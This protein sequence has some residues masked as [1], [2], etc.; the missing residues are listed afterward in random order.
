MVD[1][2]AAVL[3]DSVRAAASA[4]PLATMHD[5]FRHLFMSVLL[6]VQVLIT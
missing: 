4:A 1:A 6:G 5:Q 2:A 3:R